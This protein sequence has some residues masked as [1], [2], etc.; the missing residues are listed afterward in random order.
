[1]WLDLFVQNILIITAEKRTVK[2]GNA[3]KD[4]AQFQLVKFSIWRQSSNPS[5]LAELQTTYQ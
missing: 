3:L 5:L 4:L 2:R 1:M